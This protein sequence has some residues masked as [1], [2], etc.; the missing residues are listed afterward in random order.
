MRAS[1]LVAAALVAGCL[2]SPTA[3]P[4]AAVPPPDV[5]LAVDATPCPPADACVMDS[6]TGHT[7]AAYDAAVSWDEAAARCAEAGWYLVS[8]EDVIEAALVAELLP[9]PM[10]LGASDVDSEDD[11]RWVTG[12]PFD[13]TDWRS[14][15][16]NGELNENCLIVN[17]SGQG[18]NDALCAG[19]WSYVCESGPA[20]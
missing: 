19:T 6:R 7:Y 8:E 16:P 4:D 9:Q 14:G 10:W 18:W 20:T 1:I 15:E 2:E 5:V 13:F 11:W 17:W 12:E 3:G